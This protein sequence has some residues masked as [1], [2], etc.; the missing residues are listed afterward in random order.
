MHNVPSNDNYRNGLGRPRNAIIATVTP[1]TQ[2]RGH[3]INARILSITL[4]HTN[5]LIRRPQRLNNLGHTP[6]NSHNLTRTHTR[7]HT[8]APNILTESYHTHTCT[9][10]IGTGARSGGSSGGPAEGMRTRGWLRP[11]R[12]T[13]P[14]RTVSEGVPGGHSRGGRVAPGGDG[15]GW[16]GRVSSGSI[17]S[18][19]VGAG[20]GREGPRLAEGSGVAWEGCVRRVRIARGWHGAPFF[21][22]RADNDCLTVA[23]LSGYAPKHAKVALLPMIHH[24]FS[25]MGVCVCAVPHL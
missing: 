11:G 9:G 15:A 14:G 5:K 22:T 20:W 16:S 2:A 24:G 8:H 10:T 23:R 3:T 21:G 6:S 18:V 12:T 17:G 13:R 25:C 19:V 4:T 1:T 7:T